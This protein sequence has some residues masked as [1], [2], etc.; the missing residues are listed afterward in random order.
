MNT[1]ILRNYSLPSPRI[2]PRHRS[3]SDHQEPIRAYRRALRAAEQAAWDAA[4]PYSVRPVI[5]PASNT[6]RFAFGML[7]ATATAAVRHQAASHPEL[8]NWIGQWIR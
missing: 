5:E 6:T 3:T 2:A 4:R 8:L 1:S 7:I